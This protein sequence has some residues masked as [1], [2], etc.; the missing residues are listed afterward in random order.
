M[1]KT[2]KQ[3]DDDIRLK[4]LELALNVVRFGPNHWIV[5]LKLARVFED[6]IDGMSGAYDES[7]ILHLK[8][9]YKEQEE[10]TPPKSQ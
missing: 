3:H 1:L 6:F 9:L 7:D 5:S 10:R 8:Q 2:D 4:C